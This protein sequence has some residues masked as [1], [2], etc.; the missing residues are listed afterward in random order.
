MKE[1]RPIELVDENII[2]NS[3][4]PMRMEVSTTFLLFFY[5]PF[6]LSVLLALRKGNGENW[7]KVAKRS[8]DIIITAKS[9]SSTDPILIRYV[10]IALFLFFVFFKHQIDN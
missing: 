9:E 1:N 10:M 5:I 4:F 8:E 3:H 6:K 2:A 7:K